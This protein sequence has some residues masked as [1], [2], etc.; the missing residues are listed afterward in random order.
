MTLSGLKVG[1]IGPLPPPA[2]GM[3]NQTRQLAELLAREGATVTLVQSNA[4]YR[5]GCISRIRGVRGLFR[6]VPYLF[7]LWHVAGRVDLVHIMANSGWSWHLCAAPAIR[8][9]RWRHV[10]SV[11]NYRGGEAGTFLA[12]SRRSVGHTLQFASALVVPSGFL[13]QVFAGHALRA[14]IVPNIIDLERFRPPCAGEHP[15]APHLVV[16]RNLESIYDISTALRAFALISNA[17]PDARMTVAGSGPERA[18]LDALCRELHME[19]R[20]HFCGTR[21]RDEMAALYRSASVVINPSRVDNMPNSVLE[22]MASSVPVVS[23]NVGGV[24]FIL[25]HDITGLTVPAGDPQAMANAVLR[26][27]SDA[28]LARRLAAAAIDDV[29]Q[30]AWP[31]VRQRWSEVYATALAVGSRSS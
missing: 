7:R 2:G 17:M 6:L 16:A 15:S 14:D 30:Y 26:V 28:E 25:R 1:L 31:R 11:V 18:A 19:A 3:A 24:P 4:P 12:R 20:V 23:T 13:Q 29:Q 5:P 27:L 8:I 10:P 22:A 21:D 9:A